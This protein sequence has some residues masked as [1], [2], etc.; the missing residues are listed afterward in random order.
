MHVTPQARIELH[1]M[2]ERTL[3]RRP[4]PLESELSFRLLPA[5]GGEGLGLTLD[6]PGESDEVVLH[7]GRSVLLLDAATSMLL[8]GLTLDLV[9]TPEGARLGLL[10]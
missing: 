5:T 8:E 4:E 1:G 2:L 9:E 3:A 7:Q 10:E 6:A